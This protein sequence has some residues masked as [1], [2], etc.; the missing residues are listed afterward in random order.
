MYAMTLKIK[1]RGRPTKAE[2]LARAKAEKPRTDAAIL[3]DVVERFRILNILTNGAATGEIR[4]VSVT[5]APGIG[6]THGVQA[7][8]ENARLTDG[9]KFEVVRGAISAINLYMLAYEYRHTGNVIVLD[10]A[11]GIFQD[12]DALNIL[13]V[14]CDSSEVRTVSY[15]KEANVLIQNDIPQSFEF[16]GSMLFISNTDWQKYVD[17]GKNKFVP[18]FEALM[19]RSLYLDLRI[20][21]R[22][23]LSVWIQHLVKDARILRDAG[24]SATQEAKCLA[25]LKKNREKLRELSLRTVIKVSQ[26]MKVHNDWES[27]ASKLLCR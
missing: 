10:D 20:H 3:K 2:M 7:V 27:I 5:G 15:R 22:Q 23:E 25:F 6:K 16:K 17:E 4:A 11:D 24:F 19:S 18:H 26:L 8:L 1:K 14:L 9:T 13:K 12:E 21:S